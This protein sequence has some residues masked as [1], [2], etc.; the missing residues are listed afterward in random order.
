VHLSDAVIRRTEAGSAGHPGPDVVS[1]AAR[2]MAEELGW[3]ADRTREEIA[4]VESFYL[5]G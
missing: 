5:I 3:N 1:N 2:I 4:D